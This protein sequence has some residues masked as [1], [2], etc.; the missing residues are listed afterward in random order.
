MIVRPAHWK[1][2]V[3]LDAGDGKRLERFGKVV[4]VRPDPFALWPL[5]RRFSY[6]ALP[7]AGCFRILGAMA[8]FN[9]QGE[10]A[11]WATWPKPYKTCVFRIAIAKTL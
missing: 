1:D 4:T 6:V 7:A 9:V 10:I 11:S 8:V 2:Y 3:L 5:A